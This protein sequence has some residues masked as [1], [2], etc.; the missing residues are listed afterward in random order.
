MAKYKKYI[1]YLLYIASLLAII[2]IGLDTILISGK[3]IASEKEVNIY[4]LVYYYQF[5]FISI[6]LWGFSFWL[7]PNKKLSIAYWLTF[8]IVT[9][10][11]TL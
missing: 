6:I 1:S 2:G 11:V 3:Y 4:G 10:F 8:F 9:A 7:R 5:L